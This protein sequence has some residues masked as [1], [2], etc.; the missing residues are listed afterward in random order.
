MG[1]K[2][3]SKNKKLRA[4]ARTAYETYSYWYDKYTKGEKAGW[5]RAK[6]SEAEFKDM[7]ELAKRAGIKTN[8]AR[9]I[10]MSQEF[11]D[12]TFERKYKKFYGKKL[13]DI[14]DKNDREQIFLNFVDDL[15]AQ[16]VSYDDA[17]DEFERYFY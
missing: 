2:L 7:Y 1:R 17:R 4:K 15:T 10:A 12:R 5:F 14:R 16:G 9:T 8:R 6:L 11:V 3:G 13:G